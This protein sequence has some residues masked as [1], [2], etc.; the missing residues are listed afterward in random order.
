MH[1]HDAFQLLFSHQFFNV[2]SIISNVLVCM[3]GCNYQITLCV[4]HPITLLSIPMSKARYF[5]YQCGWSW[6]AM[7]GMA[8]AIPQAE[9]DPGG[10]DTCVVVLAHLLLCSEAGCGSGRARPCLEL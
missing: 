8:M 7:G 5:I 2:C 1:Q 3:L 4:G 10:S 6:L 9:G